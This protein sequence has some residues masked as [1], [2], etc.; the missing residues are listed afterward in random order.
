MFRQ[1]ASFSL[2]LL[3]AV[4][5]F[6]GTVGLAPAH[7]DQSPGW[8]D[9]VEQA[10]ATASQQNKDLLMNFTGSDWCVWCIK[11]KE[12]VFDK[13]DFPAKAGQHFILVELDFPN[14]K[15]LAAETRQQNE[16]WRDKFKIRGYPTLVLA[17]AKG[18]PY[19]MTG[20]REGGT[21][22]YLKH[23]DELRNRRVKRDEALAAAAAAEG[24]DLERA[25]HLDKA[26][27]AVEDTLALTYYRKVVDQIMAL[28]ADNELGLKQKY[29][30]KINNRDAEREL[31]QVF[32]LMRDNEFDAAVEAIDK[33]ME[34]YKP[35]GI[36]LQRILGIK[37]QVFVSKGDKPAAL[38]LLEQA[39][40]VDPDSPMAE[41]IKGYRKTLGDGD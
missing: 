27:D 41:Q 8:T 18:E 33:L 9:N 23:L 16:A 28:D 4:L 32:R 12:E 15:E 6:A 17:D 40:A 20:Y 3:A 38:K 14:Q 5:W 10:M 39:L 26:M 11:L 30:Q 36:T 31:M 21:A 25:K 19:A 13:D 34:Q 22:A 2:S 24:Q 7:A 37:A 35:D 1:P 29:Q